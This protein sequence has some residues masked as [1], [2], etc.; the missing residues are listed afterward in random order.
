MRISVAK[1]REVLSSL[2]DSGLAD[3][4]EARLWLWR[5]PYLHCAAWAGPITKPWLTKAARRLHEHDGHEWEWTRREVYDVLGDSW[6][7][8]VGNDT[9]ARWADKQ[10]AGEALNWI[11]SA[12]A[13]GHRHK[14]FEEESAS[15]VSR[16]IFYGQGTPRCYDVDVMTMEP[17]PLDFIA[18]WLNDNGVEHPP[19]GFH[20]RANTKTRFSPEQR[21]VFD[22]KQTERDVRVA[23]RHQ[24]E[25]EDLPF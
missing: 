1:A 10:Y 20:D 6:L 11:D 8:E 14:P 17:R 25:L 19:F 13:R 16:A 4:F 24:G 18:K 7:I 22:A 9:C 12:F 23:S 2:N 15:D 3:I 21:A 5:L